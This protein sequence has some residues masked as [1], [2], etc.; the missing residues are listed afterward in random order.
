MP[1]L[2]FAAPFFL[3]ATVRQGYGTDDTSSSKPMLGA[4]RNGSPPTRCWVCC[5]AFTR[6]FTDMMVLQ[7]PVF[8]L[9]MYL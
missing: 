1:A 4:A 3:N 6:L 8:L 5:M 7:K 9:P 2:A